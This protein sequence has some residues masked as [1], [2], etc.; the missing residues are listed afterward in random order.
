MNKLTNVVENQSAELHRLRDQF[1]SKQKQGERLSDEDTQML[2]DM[3][4]IHETTVKLKRT[5]TLS[6]DYQ[7]PV[8]A[9][10]LSPTEPYSIKRKAE[11]ADAQADAADSHGAFQGVVSVPKR[12]EGSL[13]DTPPT[14]AP[15]RIV[16]S[17]LHIPRAEAHILISELLKSPPITT[18]SS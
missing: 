7:T 10:E 4:L 14:P 5:A 18:D 17:M 3:E 12:V 11:K 13:Q 2:Q 1:V 15:E 9:D 16:P 8:E 6:E